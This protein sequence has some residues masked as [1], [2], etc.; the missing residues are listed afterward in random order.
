MELVDFTQN[1]IGDRK[2]VRNL[3]NL[4]LNNMTLV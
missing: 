4:N 3:S 1:K 2:I